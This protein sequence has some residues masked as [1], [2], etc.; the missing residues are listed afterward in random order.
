MRL[1][2]IGVLTR[3]LHWLEPTPLR[4]RAQELVAWAD[5]LEGASYKE[6]REEVRRRLQKDFPQ[7]KI[8]QL[9]TA[10]ERAIDAAH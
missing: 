2:L 9:Y 8:R 5:T 6:K 1:W 4:R 3:L 7:M 10:I